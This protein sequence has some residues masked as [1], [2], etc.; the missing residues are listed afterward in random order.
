MDDLLA[1]GLEILDSDDVRTSSVT[2]KKSKKAV[3]EGIDKLK[4][5]KKFKKQKK[6]NEQAV[7][8]RF[9][10]NQKYSANKKVVETRLK[11]VSLEQEL[12]RKHRVLRKNRIKTDFDIWCKIT[13]V[14]KQEVQAEPEDE[15]SAFDEKYFAEFEK[16]LLEK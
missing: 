7:K 14:T 6:A 5:T 9:G 1:E 15:E 8:A 4:T 12:K 16:G 2:L 10:L 13:G 11:K 3:E